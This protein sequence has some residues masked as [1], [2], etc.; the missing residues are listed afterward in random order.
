M[1]SKTY[2]AHV[3]PI[4]LPTRGPA[5]GADANAGKSRLACI[6][7]EINMET[8]DEKQ[9]ISVGRGVYRIR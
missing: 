9:L 4:Y 2:H 3:P 8:E 5:D 7:A 1:S 6:G